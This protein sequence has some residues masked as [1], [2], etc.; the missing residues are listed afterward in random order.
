MLIHVHRMMHIS[1]DTSYAYERTNKPIIVPTPPKKQDKLASV[2]K[3]H[4]RPC[5]TMFNHNSNVN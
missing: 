4:R 2:V 3:S 1:D 5:I